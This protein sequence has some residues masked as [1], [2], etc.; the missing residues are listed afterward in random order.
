MTPTA[1]AT[2]NPTFPTGPLPA[3]V[4]EHNGFYVVP[5]G[6]VITSFT[7]NG[8]VTLAG[9]NNRNNVETATVS[10]NGQTLITSL[11]GVV[12]YFPVDMVLSLIHI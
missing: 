3:G 8:I 9:G 2:I 4:Y 11:D 7:G 6:A 10:T 12:C 5:D 1:P